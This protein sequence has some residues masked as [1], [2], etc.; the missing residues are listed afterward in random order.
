MLSLRKLSISYPEQLWLPITEE[1][2]QESWQRSQLY[3]NPTSRCQ[4]YLNYLC[5]Q[6]FTPWLEAW[7]EEDGN[8]SNLIDQKYIPDIWEFVNGSMVNLGQT[9]IALI[10]SET[11]DLEE[12]DIPQ[13]WVDISQWQADYYL[14]IQVNLNLSDEAWMRVLGYVSYQQLKHKG[15]YDQSD[16]SYYIS[17]E[18]LEEDITDILLSPQTSPTEQ[19][20]VTQIELSS[21]TANELLEKLGNPSVYSPRLAIP[22][23]Q[24]EILMTNP[25]WRHK[26]YQKRIELAKV[27]LC[28]SPSVNLRKWLQDLV[29]TFEEGWQTVETLFNPIEPILVRGYQNTEKTITKEAIP[30]LINLLQPNNPEKERTQAAGVLGK[31]GVGYPEVIAA[32]TELLDTAKEEE[33]RWQAALSLGKVDP[34]NAYGGREKGKLID[35]GIQLEGQ[36]IV[37]IVAIMAQTQ[38]RV[39]VWIQ[40]KPA[41]ELMKLAPHLQLSII[42]EGKTIVEAEARSDIEGKGKDRCLQL[43]FTPPPRTHFQ[44]QVSLNNASFTEH[45]DA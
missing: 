22:F 37:L 12:F 6:T 31:I 26:L 18:Y 28:S 38:D 14:A 29:N 32:L 39:G 3:S 1:I 15:V 44:V 17:Q 30:P 27:S 36:K 41:S 20:F 33:T 5:W 8:K 11:T 10:P 16:R 34:D 7:L 23:R 2:Q 19:K 43:R 40:L 25:Q 4:A 24:W 13:E 45:F 9:K 21:V 42:S 35:L